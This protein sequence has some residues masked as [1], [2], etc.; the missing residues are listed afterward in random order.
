MVN[1]TI[2]L[3]TLTIHSLFEGMAFGL[4]PKYIDVLT[5]GLGIILHKPGEAFALAKQFE[6]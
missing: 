5:L 3:I 2:I 6:G 4:M 1:A